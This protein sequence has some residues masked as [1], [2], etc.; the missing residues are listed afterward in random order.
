MAGTHRIFIGKVI[1]ADRGETPPLIYSS[2]TYG[3]MAG[4]EAD[5]SP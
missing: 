3:R 4:I 5:D 2:R 1:S